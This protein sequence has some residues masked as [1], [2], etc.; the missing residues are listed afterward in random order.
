MN[1]NVGIWNRLTRVV[2]VLILLACGAYASQWYLPLF[3]QNE[4]MRKRNLELEASIAGEEREARRLKSSIE[5]VEND[6]RTLERLAREKL[7]YA[8]SNESIVHFEQLVP[9]A[10]SKR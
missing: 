8:K 1:V 2:V 10:S 5:A 4:R 3:Q 9:T 7:G 6:A